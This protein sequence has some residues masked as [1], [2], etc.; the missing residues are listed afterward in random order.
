MQHLSDDIVRGGLK[1]NADNAIHS[2]EQVKEILSGAN[3]ITGVDETRLM[4]HLIDAIGE[5][6]DSL[7]TVWAEAS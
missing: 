4:G 6:N 2:L 5:V 7:Q 3:I 1:I